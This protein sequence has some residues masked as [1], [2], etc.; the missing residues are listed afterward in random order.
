MSAGTVEPTGVVAS[1]PRHS[2]IIPNERR[3]RVDVSQ[4]T[5]TYFAGCVY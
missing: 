3:C 5:V 4:P 2:I 1:R